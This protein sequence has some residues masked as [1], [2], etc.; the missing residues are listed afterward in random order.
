VYLCAAQWF[1]L[2]V[3]PFCRIGR[4]IRAGLDLDGHDN[5]SEDGDSDDEYI[6][7]F[8]QFL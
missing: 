5:D 8:L 2:F 6:F 4:L 3:T 7:L 1:L